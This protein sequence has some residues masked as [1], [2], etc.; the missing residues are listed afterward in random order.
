M[1]LAEVVSFRSTL[2]LQAML[3]TP[4]ETVPPLDLC[5]SHQVA[6]AAL[7]PTKARHDFAVSARQ[8]RS[9][10]PV[11][12]RGYGRMTLSTVCQR[13]SHPPSPTGT[14]EHRCAHNPKVAGSNPAPATR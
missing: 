11:G 5:P 8:N 3:S 7:R 2:S 4:R 10:A 12:S 6:E 13:E 1:Y 9:S 14:D